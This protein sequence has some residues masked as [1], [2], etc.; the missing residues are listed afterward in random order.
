MPAVLVE[1]G[2]LTNAA[3][4]QRLAGDEHQA[5]LVQALLDGILRYRG[6]AAGT[7]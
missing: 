1:V 7:R 3:E 2:F 5:A 6:S 4:E